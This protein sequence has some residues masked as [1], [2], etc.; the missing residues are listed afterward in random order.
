MKKII[1]IFLVLVLCLSA[2]ACNGGTDLE[3]YMQK[4]QAAYD[5]LATT[6]SGNGVTMQFSARGDSL[7][8]SAKMDQKV[9][10]SVR[11][12]LEMSIG[13]S[14]EQSQAMYLSILQA[15]QQAVPSAK[16]IIVEFYDSADTLIVSKE[17]FGE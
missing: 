7:V 15:V 10:E 5:A 9:D 4:K 1:A 8:L 16:S 6:L 17:I 13:V 12:V 11:S 14:I 2:A 3:S